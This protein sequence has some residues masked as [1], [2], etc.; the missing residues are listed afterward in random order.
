MKK[1]IFAII[2]ASVSLE[3]CHKSDSTT[4][5]ANKTT[6]TATVTPVQYAITTYNGNLVVGGQSGNG[7]TFNSGI[8][9]WNGSTWSSV[10]TGIQGGGSIY[11]LIVYNGNLIAV[12][13]FENIGGVKVN[14]IAQWNGTS[15]S[16]IGNKG[17]ESAS[18]GNVSCLDIYN[19]NLIA[20]GYFDSINGIHVNSI[21]QWNGITWTPLGNGF[22]AYSASCGTLL[23]YNGNLIATGLFD[24]AGTF[25]LSNLA[26]WN[27]TVWDTVRLS[28]YGDI[29]KYG[30]NGGG[31]VW[32]GNLVLR[33]NSTIIEWNGNQWSTINNSIYTIGVPSVGSS[34]IVYGGNLLAT[35][36][37]NIQSWNG[38]A[39]SSLGSFTL[40]GNTNPTD[41][42][43]V[44]AM[45]IY[46]GNL[47][48][49][50]YFS[51]DGVA[52]YNGS[53]WT[54]L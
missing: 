47:A 23:N 30:E 40:I 16:I 43:T 35:N 20:G 11:A 4:P 37:S 22:G 17:I 32:N 51:S 53:T 52:V 33:A 9:Q 3:S 42:P 27:G 38:S 7:G 24:S 39:W 54:N 10:G 25:Q 14:G 36:G 26:Q 44:Y 50:G 31:V 41:Y 28:D 8:M 5:A 2:I 15:W 48:V 29:M 13:G 49:C 45:T 18:N 19:G 46:N 12:G 21:A 6:Q 34:V 1:F